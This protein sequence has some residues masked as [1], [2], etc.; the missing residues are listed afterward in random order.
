VVFACGTWYF[1]SF[2]C[3]FSARRPKKRQRYLIF[4]GMRFSA[5]SA[6]NRIQMIEEEQSDSRKQNGLQAQVSA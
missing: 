2:V 6:E 5:R 1:S 4:V 3:R